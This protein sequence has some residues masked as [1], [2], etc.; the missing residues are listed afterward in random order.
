[1]RDG[2]RHILEIDT[3]SRPTESAMLTL[4]VGTHPWRVDTSSSDCSDTFVLSIRDSP[5]SRFSFARRISDFISIV[6]N[7]YTGQEVLRAFDTIRLIA[8]GRL[9]SSEARLQ[10]LL[11]TQAAKCISRDRKKK[12]PLICFVDDF[13]AEPSDRHIFRLV[14]NLNSE[15]SHDRFCTSRRRIHASC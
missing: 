1:M 5:R 10:H 14:L 2:T 13:H 4:T 15:I 3:P 7:T 8:R 12:I 9:T 11:Q 6:I